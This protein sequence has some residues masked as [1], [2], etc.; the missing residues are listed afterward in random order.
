MGDL[1]EVRKD[2]LIVSDLGEPIAFGRRDYAFVPVDEDSRTD[3]LIIP[4][5]QS[6]SE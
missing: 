2:T 6:K 4:N 1:R 5:Q 3:G